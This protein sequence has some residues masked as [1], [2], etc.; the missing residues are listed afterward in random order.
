MQSAALLLMLPLQFA[1]GK[2]RTSPLHMLKNALVSDSLLVSPL[3]SKLAMPYQKAVLFSMPLVP[4][5]CDGRFCG[6]TP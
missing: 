1:H 6:T 3:A 5:L 2:M 4:Q